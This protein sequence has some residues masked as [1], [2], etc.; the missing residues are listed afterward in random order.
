MCCR[1][2]YCAVLVSWLTSLFCAPAIAS[3]VS[4]LD[5]HAL[6][7]KSDTHYNAERSSGTCGPQQLLVPFPQEAQG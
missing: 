6:Q 3:K 1:F 4:Q 2:S 7:T 5:Y